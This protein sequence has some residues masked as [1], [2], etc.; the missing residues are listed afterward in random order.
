MTHKLWVLKM[1]DIEFPAQDN[2]NFWFYMNNFKTHTV[3]IDFK[4]K[5]F[6]LNPN[7]FFKQTV[8]NWLQQ[9]TIGERTGLGQRAEF[10][11]RV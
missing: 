11:W 2:R 8:S 10:N 1:Q 9:R 4:F 7:L 6:R 3:Q 5:N